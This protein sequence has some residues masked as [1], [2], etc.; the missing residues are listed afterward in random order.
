MNFYPSSIRRLARS[1]LLAALGVGL[2]AAPISILGAQDRDS[3][4]EEEDTERPRQLTT[5]T[6]EAFAKVQ[7]LLDEKKWNEAVPILEKVLAD[8]EP[9]SYDTAMASLILA[10]VLLQRNTEGG[11]DY[12]AA[13]PLIETVIRLGYQ[14]EARLLDFQYLL[15]Q[16]YLNKGDHVKATDLAK[17]W[18]DRAP[19]WQPEKVIFYCS[20]MIQ[21][22]QSEDGS[23]DKE[24]VKK[25]FDVVNRAMQLF[26]H[27][28]ESLYRILAISYQL[29]GQMDKTTELFEV[30]VEKWPENKQ[31]WQQLY[32][33]YV[34]DAESLRAIVTLER[35][36]ELSILNSPQEN[37]A[38][39]ALHY[40]LQRFDRVAEILEKG[41]A[42]GSI[43]NTINNWEL[44]AA[45]YQQ[46]FEEF[47]AIDAHKRAAEKFPDSAGK[48]NASISNLYW[49]MENKPEALK[50]LK[51]AL[52]KGGVDDPARLYMFAAYI[53]Y[54]LRRYQEGLD[55]MAKAEP[56]IGEDARLRGEFTGLH[57][58]LTDALDRERAQAAGENLTPASSQ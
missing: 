16:L 10:Q 31:Y 15:A 51:I 22:A 18:L 25:A 29:L 9:D 38:Y 49:G 58:S 34:N 5:P 35:A 50:H 41:L 20:V 30:M 57:S 43:E 36:R 40:N 11:S 23:V 14:D 2:L 33:L 37:S 27:P 46:T 44:L 4:N 39:V 21:N 54:E 48:L 24:A 32:G 13:I 53:C 3:D 19:K 12:N 47:K 42:D 26:P 7:P 17:D 52:E 56:H 55:L 45:A 8:S 1:A 6:S 28:N